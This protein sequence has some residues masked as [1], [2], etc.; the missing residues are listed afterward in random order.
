MVRSTV[1]SKI[2]DTLLQVNFE[3]TRVLEECIVH[4]L[5]LAYEDDRVMEI[6]YFTESVTSR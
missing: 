1:R 3:E 6:L 5:R 2:T 4:G